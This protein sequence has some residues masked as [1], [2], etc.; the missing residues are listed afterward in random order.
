I[1]ENYTVGDFEKEAIAKLDDLFLTNDYVVL[2]GG[3]G[4]YVDAILKGFDDFPEIET[5]V[6][7]EVTPNYEKLGIEYLQTELEKR[8]PNYFE[9]V[10][11]ENPQRMMRALEVCIGSGKPYSSFLNQKK[12]TRNFTPILIGLEAERSLIY[13]RINQRV[14]IMMTEGLLAEAEILFP[15]KD[16]N[17]LQTVGYRELFSYFE[18]EIS[19]EFAIEEIKKNTRRFAKRQLTWFKRNGNTKWFD[20]LMDRKEIIK[21][22]NDN[23]NG[24]INDNINGNGI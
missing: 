19:L 24:N 22:I 1:F 9:V 6:R 5:S 7:G 13:D 17:A 18:G 21:N 3:S 23:I 11:K 12:N 20:Y 2:V 15:Q 4:L 10:A 16:L 14:D 8:D